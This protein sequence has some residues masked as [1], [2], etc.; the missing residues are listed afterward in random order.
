MATGWLLID[1]TWY[2]LHAINGDMQTGWLMDSSD[3][4]W[5]YLDP[6]SGAMA[7][8]WKDIGGKRYYFNPM[9]FSP[10]GWIWNEESKSWEFEKNLGMP[11]GAMY[12]GTV[13]PDGSQVDVSGAQ[14]F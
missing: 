3:G 12:S 10:S 11:S 14:I 2:Y 4:Y 13:T 1:H 9:A 6:V 7:T 5:Y 8:G